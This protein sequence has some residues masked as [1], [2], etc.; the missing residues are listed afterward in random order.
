MYCEG[1]EVLP[2]C[3]RS[4]A[5]LIEVTIR[6]SIEMSAGITASGRRATK[7]PFVVNLRSYARLILK[8][9]CLVGKCSWFHLPIG[10]PQASRVVAAELQTDSNGRGRRY[11]PTRLCTKEING[12]DG[13]PL[14]G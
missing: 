4:W 1:V 13:D 14:C 10:L 8:S 7:H 11:L 6:V 2:R 5:L 12:L 9:I 3:P